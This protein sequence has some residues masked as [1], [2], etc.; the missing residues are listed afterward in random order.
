MNANRREGTLLPMA[1]GM[2]LTLTAMA[3]AGEVLVEAEGFSDSGG[4]LLDP[5]FMDVMGSPYLLA[6]GLGKPV[7][8]ARTEVEFPETGTYHVWVRAKDWVPSHHPGRFEVIVNGQGLA[9][10]FGENGKDWSWQ[11]GGPVQIQAKKVTIELKDLTGFDGRCD[12][13]YFS[14]DA[15]ASPPAAADANMAAW[16]RKLLGLPETLPSAGE[17]DLVVVGGGVAGTCAAVTASRLGLRVALVQDRAVLGGNGS[18]EIGIGPWGPS[19]PLVDEVVKELRGPQPFAAEP[20]IRLFLGWHAFGVQKKHNRIVAVDAR[21]VSTGKEMRFSAPLFVDC[22][23]DGWIGYWAGAAY[24]QGREGYREFN[25]SRAPNEPDKRTHGNSVV[26]RTAMAKEPVSFPEVPW[27][28]EVSRDY[29]QMANIP[30]QQRDP[31]H[32]WEYGQ[33]LDTLQEAERIRDHLFCAIYGTYASVKAKHPEAAN[34]QLA[35]V[36]HI[37]AR[38]ESRRLE[39]DYILNENDAAAGRMFPDAIAY[40]PKSFFCL[41]HISTTYDFR[42]GAPR[43]AWET[44]GRQ[45]ATRPASPSEPPPACA[46]SIPAGKTPTIPFRSLYSRNIENLMIAGRCASATHVAVMNIKCMRTGGQMGIATGAAAFL[47]KK[48]NTTPRGLYERHLAELQ[49]VVFEREDY[50]EALK[51]KADKGN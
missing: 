15:A 33:G 47:C 34:L 6:H 32:F 3:Q 5:Q 41:H 8:S 12:A 28:A 25:E 9:P 39:G 23:G 17:F 11:S 50:K 45:P 14:T 43:P 30:A 37:A 44:A 4:W 48:H 2:L 36:G 26:F 38:G 10:T 35:W 51:A 27:A 29:A 49:N 40:G 21:H 19:R 7:A 22:T 18:K 20:G 31:P 16:R 42:G 13:I 46:D 24:R 1:V